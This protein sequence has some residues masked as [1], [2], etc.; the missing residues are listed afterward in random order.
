[1]VEAGLEEDVKAAFLLRNTPKNAKSAEL[2]LS[3]LLSEPKLTE[4]AEPNFVTAL[5]PKDI[6]HGQRVATAA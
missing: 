2:S 5:D 3:K 1:M 4:L 6:T